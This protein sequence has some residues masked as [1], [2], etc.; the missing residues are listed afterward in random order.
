LLALR[1]F[2]K[3]RDSSGLASVVA[4]CTM[5]N[6]MFGLFAPKCPVDLWE[7]TWTEY[8]FHWLT[9]QF[10][11]ERLRR[12]K[13]ILPTE[14]FFPEPFEGS[15][16]DA[17]RLCARLCEYMEINPA[18]L[19]IEV[20]PDEQMPGAVGRYIPGEPTLIRVVESALADEQRL[21]AVLAHELAHEALLG[22]GKLSAEEEDHELV[23]DLATV[24][25][26]V[27][28][29]GANVTVTEQHHQDGQWY[30][31]F[32]QQQG[33]L[34]SLILGYGL[35]LFAWMRG[36][37]QPAWIRHLRLDAASTMK[38]GLRYLQKTGDTL[39][40]PAR[41]SPLLPTTPIALAEQLRQGS[42]TLQLAT[43]WGLIRQPRI[44]AEVIAA[45]IER[46]SDRAAY[47]PGAA[48][49]A[50]AACNATA[51]VP[52]PVLCRVLDSANALDRARAAQA[53][54]KF[55]DQS[56]RAVANLA[57]RLKDQDERVVAAAAAALGEYGQE[58]EQA[59][60][61]LM[62]V[63]RTTL[64]QCKLDMTLVLART[65]TRITADA[66]QVVKDFFRGDERELRKMALQALRGVIHPDHGE[67]S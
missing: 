58:A 44:D 12:T 67:E 30:W 3:K 24:F 31:W 57:E 29:F 46:L 34:N 6:V 33:Y 62:P 32:M 65:L 38:N 49:E 11:L 36:E 26:G 54:G 43:M 8:R 45:L 48:A 60:R 14:E 19:R 59:V 42:P 5:E 9:E 20:V 17:G 16:E 22:G 39:C 23:T 1:V 40:D 7:K 15:V 50:L 66:K 64:V 27:G 28:L 47:I 13:V 18:R 37:E 53:L 63:L 51:A 2:V 55:R 21:A 35:A 52:V 61:L 41:L 56:G 10:G 4:S 25:L